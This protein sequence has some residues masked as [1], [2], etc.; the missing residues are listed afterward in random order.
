[1]KL[2]VGLGN[3]GETYRD[4]RH[5]VGFRVLDCVGRRWGL[6]YR[7]AGE[8]GRVA[9]TAEGASGIVLAKPR[10][11]M[12]RSGRAARRL[13]ESVGGTPEEML[14]VFDDADL[15][16]GRLRLR[17]AGGAGGHNGLRSLITVLG[18][19]RFPRVKLGVAGAGRD[20]RELADYVLDPFDV[21]EGPVVDRLIELGAD[22][23]QAVLEEG[24]GVAMNRFNGL[25]AEA[26]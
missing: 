19:D 5:N 26:N 13:L 20:E 18:S 10:T 17:E 4:T 12:N 11:Y 21:E 14:V 7:R 8:L 1:M 16:L 24:F 9:W 3:P 15:P 2:V 23:V 22:A 25:V 6:T